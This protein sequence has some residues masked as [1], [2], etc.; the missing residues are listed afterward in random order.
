[1]AS[2]PG[3]DGVGST[4]SILSYNDE[5][6][7]LM[8]TAAAISTTSDESRYEDMLSSTSS[9]E[10]ESSS[11]L[12]IPRQSSPIVP[13]DTLPVSILRQALAMEGKGLEKVQQYLQQL[14]LLYLTDTGGQLEFQELLPTITAGLPALFFV[15]FRLDQ[16]LDMTV[17][18]QFRYPNGSC[19]E[20]YQSSFTV[21]ESLLRS[22]ASIAST[23]SY[24]YSTKQE[25][26]ILLKPKVLF[27][28]THRDKITTL[29]MKR[30]D[31]CLQEMVRATSL[32]DKGV[33][34]FASRSQLMVPVNNLSS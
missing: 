16:E 28:G 23:V 24:K 21:R 13:S 19:S 30:I 1:M 9:T 29:K 10:M 31:K 14:F 12:E 6:I 18:I 4:W 27:V 8:A 2:Y 33:I 5:A 20:P 3:W 26:V 25:E 15:V 11:N 34:E 7:A 32:Y 17:E 22:L